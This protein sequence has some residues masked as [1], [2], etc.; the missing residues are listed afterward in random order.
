MVET[1]IIVIHT[2][3]LGSYII[4]ENLR[5]WKQSSLFFFFFFGQKLKETNRE[6]A[7]QRIIGN[8][9]DLPIL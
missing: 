3:L 9:S 6:K 2:A 1:Q 4:V 8:S 7:L 5:K